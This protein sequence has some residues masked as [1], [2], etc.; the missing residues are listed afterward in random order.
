MIYP[1]IRIE[2]SILSPYILEKLADANGQRP[3]DFGLEA[4]IKV[5]EEIDRKSVV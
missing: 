2:G 5:K 4:T 1:S 3:I